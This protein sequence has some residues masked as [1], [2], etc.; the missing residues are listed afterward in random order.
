MTKR[1]Q[2]RPRLILLTILPPHTGVYVSLQ[3]ARFSFQILGIFEPPRGGGHS[4]G[5]V[6]HGYA[7]IAVQVGMH[8]AFLVDR[9]LR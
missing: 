3:I 9:R 4:V 2:S 7:M 6:P 1:V 8:V 5:L